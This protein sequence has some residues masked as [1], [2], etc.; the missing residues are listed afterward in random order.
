M[1]PQDIV[2]DGNR[3]EEKKRLEDDEDLLCGVVKDNMDVFQKGQDIQ[4]T[5]VNYQ[6]SEA[7]RLVLGAYDS[8]DYLPPHSESYTQWLVSRTET[9]LD[10]DRWVMMGLIGFTTGVTGFLLHQFIDLISTT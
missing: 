10:W 4:S 9:R 3:Q 8:Q 6:Y 1:I 2:E 5:N 7:E